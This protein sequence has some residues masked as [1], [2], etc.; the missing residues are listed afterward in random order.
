MSLQRGMR[1]VALGTEHRWEAGL[2]ASHSLSQ[3]RVPRCKLRLQ[4]SPGPEM[5]MLICFPVP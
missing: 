2:G 4:V 1:D 5:P 3:V